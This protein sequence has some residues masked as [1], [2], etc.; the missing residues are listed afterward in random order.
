[1]N[2]QLT[3]YKLHFTS[4]LHIGSVRDDYGTSMTTI[5]SDAMYAALT[6]CLAKS[7]QDIPDDG[8]LKCT[9]SNLFPFYQKDAGSEAIL[10]LPRPLQTV[11]PTDD[12]L[13]MKEN[14]KV[15]WLE[16]TVFNE[17]L[18]GGNPF[19]NCKICGKYLVKQDS[20]FGTN[21]D[22][23]DY[24]DFVV[25]QV[26][27][28]VAIEDRTGQ[29]DAKPFYMDRI[30][31][32]DHSGLFFIATGDT[33]L[34]DKAMRLL[35]LEGIGTDRNVGNGF[36]TYETDTVTFDLPDTA[37]YVLSLSSFIPESKEQLDGM[38]S[39]EKSAYGLQRRG[40]WIT[41]PPNQSLRKNVI[42]MLSAG[43]VLMQD[44]TGVCTMGRMVDLRPDLQEVG[45]PVWR[46]GKAL[47]LPIKL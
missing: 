43:S 8:D 9:I 22:K 6:A 20:P 1:M 29:S 24:T 14:K 7:G 39:S 44:T 4:P 2:K 3:I 36:F 18:N 27:E 38:L 16:L 32:R 10:F 30:S 45:H 5:S 23:Q 17:L 25:S 37:E 42:Y 15:V 33:A 46:N 41:T 11:V 40:G 13:K 34:L 28:R 12:P 26:S 19:E 21:L 47:F 35:A 31:F